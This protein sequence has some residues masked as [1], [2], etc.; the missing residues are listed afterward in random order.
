M[1]LNADSLTVDAIWKEIELSESYLVCSIYG[2]AASLASSVLKRLRD[3]GKEIAFPNEEEANQVYYDMLESAG[4]V[5][6]QSLKELGRTSEIVNQLRV[7]FLSATAVPAQVLLTG[8]C[9]HVADGSLTG[10]REFLEEFLSGWSLVG[11]QYCAVVMEANS[12]CE[13]RRDR[14]FVME[15]DQYL[16]VV[17]IYSVTLLAK[18]LNDVDLAISWVEKAS[19]PEEKRQGLLRRLHSMYSLQTSEL[20]QSSFQHLPANNNGAYSLKELNAREGSAKALKGEQK[21]K[22]FSLKEAV[23]RLSERME[24]CFWCFGT[25]NLKFGTTR[26]S[27]SSGRILLGCL[28]LLIYYIATKKLAT[29]KRIVR[30]QATA[31]KKALVDFW[32]LAF[33]YQVNPLA[34]V[35]PLSAVTREGQ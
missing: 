8:V 27:I 31:V 7:C 1:G 18:A 12:A 34:A 32:Q 30:G 13:I 14:K 22:K 6:V 11:E 19:L 25:I 2:E 21:N 23:L 15:V 4:M 20:S 10:I 33:S 3:D 5:L 28:I 26:F 29:I 24:S 9:F 35:Q 16:E 17:E